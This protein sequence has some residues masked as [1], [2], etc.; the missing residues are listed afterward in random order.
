LPDDWAPPP[1]GALTGKVASLV[2]Q[3]PPGAYEAACETFRL[4][5]LSETGA[6]ALKR[7]WGAALAKWLIGD[8]PKI[9]R[10]ARA[11]VSFAH[12]ATAPAGSRTAAAVDPICDVAAKRREDARSAA[13]HTALRRDLGAVL[14]GQW[15]AQAALI[16][17]PEG[18]ADPGLTVITASAFICGWIEDRFRLKLLAAARGVLG[19]DAVKWVRFEV[20]DIK[21][22][23]A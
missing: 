19:A 13:L 17:S 7:D 1:I 10:D 14:H 20:E 23:A 12:L 9:M 8:H 5:W 21:E 3:W 4:H 22:R 2:R 11:G 18:D 16:V 6:R 15:I